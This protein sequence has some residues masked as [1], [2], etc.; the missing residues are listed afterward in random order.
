MST[1]RYFWFFFGRG[2]FWLYI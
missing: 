2:Y 1:C